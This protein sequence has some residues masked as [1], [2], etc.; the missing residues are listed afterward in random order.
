MGNS[1]WWTAPC[2]LA[3]RR[4]L[5][6]PASSVQALALGAPSQ[7]LCRGLGGPGL[8]RALHAPSHSLCWSK[9]T[10]QNHAAAPDPFQGVPALQDGDE[11]PNRPSPPAGATW[12]HR[13]A[14][15]DTERAPLTFSPN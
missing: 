12:A 8:W 6:S 3:E 11:A 10:A 15:G 9:K 4:L 2:W 1:P 5:W 13:L 14:G 7:A